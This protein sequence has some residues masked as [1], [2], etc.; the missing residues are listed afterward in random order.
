MNTD[1][2][3]GTTIPTDY[4]YNIAC[5]AFVC[6]YNPNGNEN[7]D[8]MLGAKT[9]EGINDGGAHINYSLEYRYKG[10]DNGNQVY[11]V[12]YINRVD[13]TEGFIQGNQFGAAGDV[14][15][16]PYDISDVNVFD[17]NRKSI[18]EIF[19]RSRIRCNVH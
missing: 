10:N 12:Y 7:A 11:G 18:H 8:G 17:R 2:N 15:I 5:G 16:P 6:T 4:R 3:T 13:G 14:Y 9:E 19:C 1:I